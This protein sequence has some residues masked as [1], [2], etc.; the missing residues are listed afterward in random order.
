LKNIKV[1]HQLA[2]LDNEIKLKILALLVDTGAKSITDISKILNLNFSTAHKYLEQLE[3]AGFVK[4]KQETGN[5]L[6]R[7]FYIQDFSININSHNI[8]SVVRGDELIKEKENPK[9]TFNIITESGLIEQFDKERFFA[10]YTNVGFP[11]NTIKA[12][13]NMIESDF[14]DGITLIEIKE[15]FNQALLN[16]LNTISSALTK[17]RKDELY[18]YNLIKSKLLL[19]N[20]ISIKDHINGEIFIQNLGKPRIIHFVHDIRSIIIHGISGKAPKNIDELFDDLINLMSKEEFKR[21]I[22]SFDSFNFF[23]APLVEK[24]NKEELYNK[25]LSFFKKMDMFHV[26]IYLGLEHGLPE[27]L[28]NVPPTFFSSKKSYEDFSQTAKLVFDI[29]LEIIKRN[30]LNI[31]VIVKL[32][33]T[34]EIMEIPYGNY[35]ANMNLDWQKPNVSYVGTSCFDSSWRGWLTTLRVGE[36]ENISINLPAIAKQSNSKSEFLEKIDNILNKVISYHLSIAEHVFGY[37]IRHFNTT[38]PSVMRDKWNYIDISNFQYNVSLYGLELLKNFNY[39]NSFIKELVIKINSK[40][41]TSSE[42]YK[43]RLRLREEKHRVIINYFKHINKIKYNID[44]LNIDLSI[45]E[46]IQMY[47]NGGYVYDSNILNK[48]ILNKHRLIKVKVKNKE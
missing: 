46:H 10:L 38:Y 26:K 33:N 39:S 43:L 11:Q 30:K 2:I 3:Q 18:D 6:K 41:I 48:E 4:S 28:K 37:S 7:M 24:L 45:L 17:I 12:I 15:K 19:S 34:N 40:L 27:H 32:N 23:I 5:R 14:Y 9:S 16:N 31:G 21:T 25:L 20:P 42:R 29:I 36:I 8:S 44:E 35:I 47:L 22:P 1:I 13:F